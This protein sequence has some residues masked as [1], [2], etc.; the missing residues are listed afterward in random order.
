MNFIN[1]YEGNNVSKELRYALNN[2]LLE[3]FRYGSKKFFEVIL[4]AKE[5]YNKGEL[6]L[7]NEDIIGLLQTDIGE[8]AI[9]EGEEVWLDLPMLD[10]DEDVINEKDKYAGIKASS[11]KRDSS[12]GK[13]YKVYVA[14]CSEKTDTNPRGI[15]LLRFGSGGLKAK[16][17]DPEARK[18]FDARHGCSKGKHNDKCKPGYW[19]CRLP[20]FASKVGLNYN[21]S[22]QWW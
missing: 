11:P 20:T 4:E 8:K 16:L 15:T 1:T 22:A 12:G 14:G 5:K 2:G 19:S 6:I 10:E 3:S 17:D 13:A 9:Y 21:G 7:E 18:R